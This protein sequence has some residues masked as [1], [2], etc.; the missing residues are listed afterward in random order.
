MLL[1][2]YPEDGEQIGTIQQNKRLRELE[3]LIVTDNAFGPHFVEFP[4]E[5]VDKHLDVRVGQEGL[6]ENIEANFNE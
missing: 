3:E 1:R 5:G 2:N 6:G 4:D